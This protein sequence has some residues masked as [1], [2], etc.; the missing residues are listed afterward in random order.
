M[1]NG[2]RGV[3]LIGG[4]KSHNAVWLVGQSTGINNGVA[5]CVKN[6]ITAG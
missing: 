4:G 6:G 2:Q 3:I 1:I 5:V